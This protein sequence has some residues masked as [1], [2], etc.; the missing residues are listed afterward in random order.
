VRGEVD[1]AGEHHGNQHGGDQ[2]S[3][4]SRG[5]AVGT[6]VL[7]ESGPLD[8]PGEV[9]GRSCSR[10]GHQHRRWVGPPGGEDPVMT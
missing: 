5:E 3:A 2:R 8:H 1:E 9:P 4:S 6:T 10:S 7:D